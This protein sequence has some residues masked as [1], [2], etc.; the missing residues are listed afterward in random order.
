VIYILKSKDLSKF[1]VEELTGFLS[2]HEA[3]I[4]L[5]VL[6]H[7]F[8]SKVSIDKGSGRGFKVRK[9]RGRGNYQMEEKSYVANLEHPNQQQQKE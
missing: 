2:S 1:L 3:R 7:E 8:K 9:G 4:N 5:D 6:E